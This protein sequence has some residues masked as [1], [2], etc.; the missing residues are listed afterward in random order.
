MHVFLKNNN[1][2][3]DFV[4]EPIPE[5]LSPVNKTLDLQINTY[6]TKNYDLLV[7]II[8]PCGF[9]YS[10]IYPHDFSIS[11]LNKDCLFYEFF[12][13][14][15]NISLDNV[16]SIGNFSKNTSLIDYF[17]YNCF[18]FKL[19][20]TCDLCFFENVEKNEII[21]TISKVQNKNG[22]AIIKIDS[23]NADLIYF[24]TTIYENVSLFCSKIALDHFII[25]QNYNNT[26]NV[27]YI[28]GFKMG[29][30]KKIPLYFLN[31]IN[32]Y[33]CIIDQRIFFN[34]SQIIFY[35]LY[36]NSEKIKEI[37][38]KNII[39][40]IKWCQTYGI[41]HHNIKINMFSDK[42]TVI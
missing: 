40:S 9:L 33:Y 35:S 23:K 15:A 36:E 3:F 38:N 34:K 27:N 26:Y 5:I 42:I 7:K 19:N 12:E 4:D 25:C 17:L 21:E 14:F 32:E 8:E 10:K 6:K 29:I 18:L 13:I 31:I 16:F 39:N 41:P 28:S 37:K 20:T 1:I 30:H 11:R 2:V 22:M 24:L